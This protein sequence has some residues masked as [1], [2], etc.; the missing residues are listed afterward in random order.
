MR[1]PTQVSNAVNAGSNRVTTCRHEALSA[2]M[3]AEDTY[4]DAVNGMTLAPGT[5]SGPTRPTRTNLR[6]REAHA[7]DT[8][9]LL[10]LLRPLGSTGHGLRRRAPPYSQPHDAAAEAGTPTRLA[11]N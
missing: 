9:P 3:S 1:L 6:G 10:L 4:H 11:N 8:I 7:V 5:V 2:A